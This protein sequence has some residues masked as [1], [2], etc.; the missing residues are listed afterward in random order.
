MGSE[1]ESTRPAKAKRIR[2]KFT[3]WCCG[4]ECIQS[5]EPATDPR[6][7]KPVCGACASA[8]LAQPS[9]RLPIGVTLPPAR[10]TLRAA[11]G[12][13]TSDAVSAHANARAVEVDA[14]LHDVREGLVAVGATQGPGH[15]AVGDVPAVTAE[16][17]RREFHSVDGARV[18][19][20][21]AGTTGSAGDP[22][23]VREVVLVAP[24]N[25]Q[26]DERGV[27]VGRVQ[28]LAEERLRLLLAARTAPHDV[29][30]AECARAEAFLRELDAAALEVLR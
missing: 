11:P 23:A 1:R 9:A 19:E 10:V 28:P 7:G 8:C 6:M 18:A 29:W 25:I 14:N 17:E 3:C 4:D 20:R 5:Y 21:A 22:G 16:E 27:Y 13:A 12:P 15:G 24:S 26:R 30:V 2:R